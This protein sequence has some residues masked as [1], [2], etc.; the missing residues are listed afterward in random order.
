MEIKTSARVHCLF[1]Q[2]GT[3]RDAFRSLGIHSFDYDISNDFGETNYQVDLFWHIRRCYSG[4]AGTIFDDIT[5]D[6]LTIAFF[7]CTWFC[8]FNALYFSGFS[9][10]FHDNHCKRNKELL[11]RSRERQEAWECALM[12]FDIFE[13]R[14]LRL[15][16]E[17]PNTGDHYLRNNFPYHP[18]YIDHNRLTRGDNFS[19]P[20]QYW[21]VNCRPSIR[22]TYKRDSNRERLFIQLTK[23]I[24]RSVMSREYAR[25]FICDVILGVP[26]GGIVQPDLFN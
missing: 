4:T 17:Q 25:N 2:S 9:C 26:S 11:R 5:P 7:P 23:G 1:E 6:D 3:F 15:V 18:D 20:T 19:K 24:S 22:Q 14:G 13:R 8:S 12:L 21:F 16:V 10:N